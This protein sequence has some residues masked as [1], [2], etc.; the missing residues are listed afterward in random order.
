M[1]RK[2][3]KWMTIC[4]GILTLA[5]FVGV[6]ISPMIK[7][8]IEASTNNVSEKNTEQEDTT[9]K[10]QTETDAGKNAE[11]TEVVLVNG[12]L[13][14]TL[15]NGV[16]EEDVEIVNDYA[17]RIVYVRFANVDDEF[18]KEK[19]TKGDSD[20]IT[21]ISYE[22]ED[23][24]GVLAITLNRACEHTY[25]Y[26]DGH[27]LMDLTDVHEL[28][29]KIVV[30]DAGH[31]GSEPGA[32]R[33][34]INEKKLNLE[35]VLEIKALFDQLD[36]KE[37]KVFYTRTEDKH[38]SLQDRAA[39]ANSLEADL[40]ISIHNNSQGE[41]EFNEING[42]MVLFSEGGLSES[43]TLARKCLSYVVESTGSKSQGLIQGDYVYIVRTSKVPVALIEVGFMTNERELD[44]LA[45]P[46][47][48]RKVAN[49]VYKAI[50]EALEE[51]L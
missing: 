11:D 35:I 32:I 34:G 22:K 50:M 30:I 44:N 21:S 23:E 48:Q 1:E 43:E 51:G 5:F 17:N 41:E 29:D 45:S 39:L 3:L 25:S 31:G 19:V 46:A 38:V 27:L 28:Y 12:D 10:E 18:S 15:P 33:K 24:G 20:Y 13:D 49:G 6:G 4:L 36:E 2:V 42:T 7:D 9:D 16:K 8:G 47:Y 14:I 26:E 37:V 40:F